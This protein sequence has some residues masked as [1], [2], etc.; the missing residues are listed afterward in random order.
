MSVYEA[1][2]KVKSLSS[3][4]FHQAKGA[5]IEAVVRLDDHEGKRQS[6][7]NAEEHQGLSYLVDASNNQYV[8]TKPKDATVPLEDH[9]FL[10]VML[11]TSKWHH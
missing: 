8:L 6:G 3:L 10:K 7:A 2:S 1:F 4:F 11:L 9:M 5:Q